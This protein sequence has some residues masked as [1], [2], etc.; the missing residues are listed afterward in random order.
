MAKKDMKLTDPF[1]CAKTIVATIQKNHKSTDNFLLE[2]DGNLI[3][4][5]LMKEVEHGIRT[6]LQ[7]DWNA[8]D[9]RE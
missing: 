6:R 3:G 5:G 8:S 9:K 2:L 4:G 7:D 1:G